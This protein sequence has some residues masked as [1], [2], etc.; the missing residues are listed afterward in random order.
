MLEGSGKEKNEAHSRRTFLKRAGIVAASGVGGAL[1]AKFLLK[2]EE[3]GIE[4]ESAENEKQEEEEKVVPRPEDTPTVLK[5]IAFARTLVE[6]GRPKD[7]LKSPYLVHALYYSDTFFQG[8]TATI[9]SKEKAP[10][11]LHI[12]RG[13]K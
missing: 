7:F 9:A 12:M 6:A 3:K 2:Q 8:L 10:E 5:E 13:L 4:Q 1:V 11:S